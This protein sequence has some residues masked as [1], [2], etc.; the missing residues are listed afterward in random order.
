MT[1]ISNRTLLT[2]IK[3]GY[4]IN[5]CK[6]GFKISSVN[7]MDEQGNNN[8][9]DNDMDIVMKDKL[10]RNIGGLVDNEKILEEVNNNRSEFPR[11]IEKAYQIE[12]DLQETDKDLKALCQDVQDEEYNSDPEV[13]TELSKELLILKEKNDDLIVIARSLEDNLHDGDASSPV[14]MHRN[15]CAKLEQIKAS[16]EIGI[17]SIT[18][19]QNEGF[20]TVTEVDVEETKIKLENI[21]R[22]A[23][24]LHEYLH[25]K[26]LPPI[27]N[28]SDSST[29]MASNVCSVVAKKSALPDNP[30]DTSTENSSLLDDFADTSTEPVD[31]MSGDD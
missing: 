16:A 21:K 24:S 15:T 30:A 3:A 12:K 18:N 14:K 10:K 17:E 20:Q 8:R 5:Q 25:A 27:N 6:R 11:I 26:D 31:Y 29:D 19:I 1:R 7:R 4:K 23:E 9:L 28:S 22:E 13:Q 2:F